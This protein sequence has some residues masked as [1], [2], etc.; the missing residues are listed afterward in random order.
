MFLLSH[1]DG[2]LRK[3]VNQHVADRLPSYVES[4]KWP[5]RLVVSILSVVVG[6]FLLDQLIW[7]LRGS[8]TQQ[9]DVAVF[10]TMELK[11]H[12][13]DYG[14]PDTELV[15]CE[16]TFLPFPGLGGSSQPCW[17]LQRH[18]QVIRRY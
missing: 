18:R 1:L 9:V 2:G 14:T 3:T 8:P 6:S 13:E 17:W 15:T 4:M 5:L 11:N 10:T 16:V 7:T 12:K